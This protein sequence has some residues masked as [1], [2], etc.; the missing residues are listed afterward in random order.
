[1]R[2]GYFQRCAKELALIVGGDGIA[3]GFAQLGF[4]VLL[5]MFFTPPAE[6]LPFNFA[7]QGD[8]E[9]VFKRCTVG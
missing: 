1:M 2:K 8:G 4:Q 3:H 7:A 5:L 9:L 6:G